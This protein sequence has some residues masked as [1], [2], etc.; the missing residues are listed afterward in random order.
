M[1]QGFVSNTG[2]DAGDVQ[3]Q[4]VSYLGKVS[5]YAVLYPY[6]LIGKPPL[7]SAVWMSTVLHDESNKA[8][9]ANAITTRTKNLQD[10]ET[11]LLNHLT[12]TSVFLNADGQLV[13][14]TA[15]ETI[16]TSTNDV[17]VTAPNII[18]NGNVTIDGTLD[19]TGTIKG[20]TGAT[21]VTLS[22][23][24]HTGVTVGAGNTG[25]PI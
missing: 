16:I 1:Y 10:G 23:H 25:G 14:N 12:G 24:I 21:P 11:G 6:G 18:I 5:Q 2:S 7:G 13:I 17:T 22:A 15:A 3:Q 4:Q 20:N 9:I 8:G 19:A